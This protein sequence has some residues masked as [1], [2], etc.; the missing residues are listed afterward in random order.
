MYRCLQCFL[1]NL[2]AIANNKDD[3]NNEPSTSE[4]SRTETPQTWNLNARF[5]K[6]LD[7]A[8][9]WRILT[10]IFKLIPTSHIAS[11]YLNVFANFT[12]NNSRL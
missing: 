4:M 7:D 2:A 12:C 1:H 9:T 10:N 11:N 8:R 6:T 3:L 5:A